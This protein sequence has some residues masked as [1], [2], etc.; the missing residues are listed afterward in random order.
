MSDKIVFPNLLHITQA[1]G[2][3]TEHG[4]ALLGH[5]SKVSAFKDFFDTYYVTD[6][7]TVD[8]WVEIAVYELK[9]V[10]KFKLLRKI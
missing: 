6:E 5:I 9:E 7:G 4:P 2:S 10:Q 1:S 8:D 3:N